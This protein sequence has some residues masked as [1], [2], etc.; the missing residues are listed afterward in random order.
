MMKK[1][2]KKMVRGTGILLAMT[3]VALGA[4]A[5]RVYFFAPELLNDIL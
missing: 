2:M 1:L 5:L 4:T 3:I